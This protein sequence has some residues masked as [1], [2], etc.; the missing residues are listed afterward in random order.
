MGTNE[1]TSGQYSEEDILY[2]WRNKVRRGLL[3]IIILRMFQEQDG[4]GNNIILN[5][6]TIMERI[7]EH[8]GGDWDPSPGS[9]YP[10]LSEMEEDGMIIE[11]LTDNLKSRDYHLTEFGRQ[12]Y[13]GV[14]EKG[15][16]PGGHQPDSSVHF[17][18]PAFEALIT[19]RYE[20]QRLRDIKSDYER[21]KAITRILEDLLKEK[22]ISQPDF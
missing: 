3:R 6:I 20:K 9:I 1:S 21:Y 19:Q 4:N 16:V 14:I 7:K 2:K 15:M 11:R 22:V 10:I 18:S 12:I 5:G 17:S 13:L 8:T